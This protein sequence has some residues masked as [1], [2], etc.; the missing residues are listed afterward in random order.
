MFS[1]VRVGALSM[2]VLAVLATSAIRCDCDN[3]GQCATAADCEPRPWQ[4]PNCT[5]DEG[6]WECILDSCVET[7]DIGCA[8]AADC[9]IQD[10][11]AEAGCAEADGHWEC[12]ASQCEALCDQ[13]ECSVAADCDG[14]TWPG[15][16]GCDA[17]DGHWEC[18]ADQC[19]AICD[20]PEC[21]EAVECDGNTW[22]GDA[23]CAEADGHWECQAGACT[24]ICDPDCIDYTD[25]DG[26]TWPPE[27]ELD[28]LADEGHWEC[29]AGE[30]VAYCNEEC[31]LVA[32]CQFY[33]WEEVC[34]GH[35]DCI[36]GLC[37]EVC[38]PVG[39]SDGA[40]DLAS[41]ETAESCP[42]DCVTP[43]QVP[44]DCVDAGS[45]WDQ[46]CVG[47]WSC[48]QGACVPTCDY[49]NCDDGG[50]D[51]LIGEDTTSCPQDCE[52]ACQLPTDC[53]HLD[54]TKI[55]QGRF[56][57]SYL[58]ECQ[59][60]C[61]VM[62]TCPNGDC[63]AES[64]ETADSCFAD[65][66]GGPCTEVTDCLGYFWYE[67][68]CIGDGGHWEC[69]QPAGACEPV[70]DEVTCGDGTCDP[71]AGESATGCPADCQEYDCDLTEHCD[72]LTLP[73]GCSAWVC[74]NRNCTP[75]CP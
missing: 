5:A 21:A 62:G 4:H 3:P 51:P 23:G 68:D 41:G 6:H 52:G 19:E 40:C 75:V 61:D 58:G 42:D 71:L 2:L 55:C 72:G 30:C 50:C 14:N 64:G 53:T 34:Q 48:E 15:D 35:F 29:E 32:D 39:C 74:L 49:E 45:E 36:Q 70:C 10:W 60:T 22:P 20:Q 31:T 56:T 65:C 33:T 69:Q 73:D 13:P 18:N 25:C 12:N 43:C 47:H 46:P 24:A 8:Q 28:C 59:E 44:S 9:E 17:A 16:A 66:L 57:C 27:G 26:A 38:D 67:D 54:W 37:E 63:E 1:R 7:C 11:P